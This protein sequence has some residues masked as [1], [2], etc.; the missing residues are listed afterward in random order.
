MP[1]N[2]WLLKMFQCHINVEICSS[3]KVIKYLLWY[4]FKG[5]TRVIASTEKEKEEEDEENE[6]KRF[7][8]M[9]TVGATEAFWRLYEFKLHTRCP[10]VYS[11]AIHLENQQEMYFE[12]DT[13]VTNLIEGE[14]KRTQ[15][16]AFFEYNEQNVGINNDLTYV[17]FA[18]KFAYQPD[19]NV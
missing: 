16:T 12:N 9:R 13:M 15:L 4:P 11:L 8:D 6:V 1:H 3:L 5:E 14:P 7:L 18:E 10:C 19:K 17:E 2:L